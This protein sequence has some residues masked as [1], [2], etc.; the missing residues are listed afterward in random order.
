MRVMFWVAWA[1]DALIGA[2]AVFFFFV[3]L[4]D[5]SVSSFNIVLWIV[6]LL[7]V[8][9]VVGGS[10]FLRSIGY[11]RL[12]LALVWLPAIPGFLAVLFFIVVLITQP[13]WN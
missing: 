4:A 6:L 5:G 1:L 10:L 13:R 2:I 3:G 7:A 8:A 9:V 12:A 11:T